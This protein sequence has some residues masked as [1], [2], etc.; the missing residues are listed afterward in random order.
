MFSQK[1][2]LCKLLSIYVCKLP[3]IYASFHKV[4]EAMEL[5]CIFLN[6]PKPAKQRKAK[7]LLSNVR[8]GDVKVP[9]TISIS[10]TNAKSNMERERET[11]MQYCSHSI[12][13]SIIS[14]LDILNNQVP[15]YLRNV[16]KDWNQNNNWKQTELSMSGHTH[17]N[18][19]HQWP[20]FIIKPLL[21]CGV[22][23]VR[24][25]YQ[26]QDEKNCS[27]KKQ[28]LPPLCAAH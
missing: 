12:A 8:K 24:C 23:Y 28:F 25:S 4:E 6:P 19:S 16:E 18:R 3:S 2:H 13:S 5:S 11:F 7:L 1:K 15:N 21:I 26:K 22:K 9:H 27:K 10:L 20:A 14:K 17:Y